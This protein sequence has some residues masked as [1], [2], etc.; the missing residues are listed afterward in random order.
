MCEFFI[1]PSRMHSGQKDKEKEEYGLLCAVICCEQP[2]P[3]PPHLSPTLRTISPACGQV[4]Q[5]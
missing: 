2:P 1:E 3:P 4:Y 5:D